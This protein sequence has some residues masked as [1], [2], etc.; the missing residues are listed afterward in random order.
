[1]AIE[2]TFQSSREK[3]FRRNSSGE[4]NPTQIDRSKQISDGLV[5]ATFRCKIQMKT[6]EKLSLVYANRNVI[7]PRMNWNLEC[8]RDE[9]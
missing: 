8:E 9:F 3:F 5:G 4:R 2:L 1:M 6:D 7:S